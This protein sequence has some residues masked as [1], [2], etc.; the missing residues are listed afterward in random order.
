MLSLLED[1]WDEE[2]IERMTAWFEKVRDDQWKGGASF[3]GYL[4]YM[5]ESFSQNQSE[6]VRTELVAR[7]PQLIADS[8]GGQLTFRGPQYGTWLSDDEVL[9]DLVYNPDSFDTDPAEGVEAY[10]KAF[11]ATCHTFGPLGTEAGP[12]LTTIGQRFSR[13]DLVESI[14]RPSYVVSELWTMHVLTKTDGQRI[15]GTIFREDAGEVMV[16]LPGGSLVSVPATDIASREEAEV[17]AMP[18]GLLNNLGLR[19]MRALIAL[20][21][22]GPKAIPDSLRTAP[23]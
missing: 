17:S 9:E 22:A 20:L 4:A 15:S 23:E 14:L 18:E 5:L 12:D 2:S 21:T 19:E 3:A 1:G 10:E 11:C 6:E 13:A 8:E 7:L 16:Q